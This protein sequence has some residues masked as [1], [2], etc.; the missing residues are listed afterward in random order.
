MKYRFISDHREIFRVGRMCNVLDVSRSSYYAWLHRPESTRKN[1]NRN[2]A[3][4][5]R[6]IH[7]Q[8]R[9]TY[10][11]PRIHKELNETGVKC[12]QNRVARIMKQEGIRAIV[13]RKYRK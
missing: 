6:V 12:S 13:P 2:L 8:K 5:I 9:K 3:T 1:E 11:S 10:G 4:R 7:G